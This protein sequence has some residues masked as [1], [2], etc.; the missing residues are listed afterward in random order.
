MTYSPVDRGEGQPIVMLHGMFG[1][2]SNWHKTIEDLSSR[3]RTIALEMPYLSL[4][5]E[6]SSVKYLAR[7]VLDTI[8][9]MGVEKAIYMGNSLGGHIAL[10]IAVNH[11]DNIDGLVL[12]GSSGLFE[13]SYEKDLQIHPTR[14]Y[15]KKKVSEMFF[16]QALISDDLV[17]DVYSALTAKDTRLKALRMFKAAKNYNMASLLSKVKCPTLLVWGREDAITPVEVAKEFNA[18]IKGSRLEIIDNCC[19][20]PMMEYSER[21]NEIAWEF[22]KTLQQ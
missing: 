22:L 17:D 8:K 21:F 10:E 5:K 14:P 9:S 1:H 3:Y 15:V 13:R 20:A 6:D 19:H 2:A 18:G 4:S 16:D 11:R 7:Y 12:T